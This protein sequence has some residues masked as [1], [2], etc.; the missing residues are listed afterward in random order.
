L[1]FTTEALFLLFVASMSNSS[2]DESSGQTSGVLCRLARPQDLPGA[3]G[4]ILAQGRW[5]AS[6]SQITEFLNT[7]GER[8]ID[9]SQ[10]W[11]AESDGKVVWTILPVVS[12]GRTMLLISP[13]HIPD[14]Q[15]AGDLI[16]SISRHY[17]SMDVHLGQVLLETDAKIACKLYLS[18]AFTQVAELIYLQ[19]NAHRAARVPKLDDELNWQTYSPQTHALFASAIR[20]SYHQSLDCPALSGKREMEDVILGHKAT[21]E[22]DPNLWFVLCRNDEPLGVLLLSCIP[23]TDVVELVYLGLTPAARGH[24]LGDVLMRQAMGI[25][26]R[27]NRRRL[28]LAV[29][30]TNEP[31]LRLYYRHG[32]QR[33]M[34][35]LAM[36]RDLRQDR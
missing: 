15:I 32:M 10:C 13:P 34:S 27:E 36:I 3:A 18:H 6:A 30:S 24:G 29:D 33:T 14:V 7:A 5:P 2:S 19:A 26:L 12:P 25:V 21:G 35:K 31:A 20:Q 23:R 8:S 28:N 17:A 1:P 9:L 22:F 16:E 11:I 4:L